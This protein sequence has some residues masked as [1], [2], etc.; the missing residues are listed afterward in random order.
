MTLPGPEVFERAG[1]KAWPGIEVEWD[2]SWVR[3]AAGGYT[4]R[5]NSVQ[6]FDPRDDGDA[7]RRL[8][9]SRRWFE[10]RGLQPIVRMT[11]LAGP[12]LREALDAAGWRTVDRSHLFAMALGPMEGDRRVRCTSLLDP[13]FLAAQRALQGY[14]E[15]RTGR[16]RALLAVIDVPAIGLVLEDGGEPVASALMAIADGIVVTGNVVTRAGRR[17]EGFGAA[18][19]RTGLAWAHRT[20]ATLAALNVTAGNEAAQ[21]LYRG[22]G[23]THQYDYDYRI[24]GDAA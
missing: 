23:Y 5:A 7:D 8:A 17:R 21:S 22:L 2:G 11:P 4:Q 15:E 12:G 13:R 19:M 14:S 1:L 20:G 10:D 18:L 24:P 9:A 6:S 16:M 3:R